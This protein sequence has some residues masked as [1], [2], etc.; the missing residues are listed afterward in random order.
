MKTCTACRTEQAPDCFSVDNRNGGL[1]SICKN[2]Y[3]AQAK[4][5][6]AIRRQQ[7]HEWDESGTKVCSECGIERAVIE[8]SKDRRIHGKYRHKCMPCESK[9]LRL[10]REQNKERYTENYKLR[11]QLMPGYYNYYSAQRRTNILRA[12]PGW[13][14]GDEFQKFAIEEAY[15]LARQREAVTG[16]KW[17]VDH[18]I[19]L[20]G[21]RVC[22]LHVIENLRVIPKI[23]NRMKRNLLIDELKGAR[24]GFF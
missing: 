1:R 24:H 13:T 7:P 8:F 9:K 16:G 14:E 22:G 20:A 15:L 12:I 10:W 6:R 17:E 21:K 4:A 2:C 23:A 19:P 3:N 18:I 11:A 5:L